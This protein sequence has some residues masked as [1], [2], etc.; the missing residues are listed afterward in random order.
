MVRFSAGVQDFYLLQSVQTGPY[1]HPSS[2]LVINRDY[3]TLGKAA[4]P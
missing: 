1:T 4:W 3:V 2:Y